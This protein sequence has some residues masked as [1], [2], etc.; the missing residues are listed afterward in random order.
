MKALYLTASV[1]LTG[2]ILIIAFGNINA[3]CNQLHFLFYP[4]NANPT[5]VVIAMAVIGMLTGAFYHAFV[6]RVLE[7]SDEEDEDF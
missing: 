3:Q 4:V 5:I 6:N 2:L 7:S 1:I